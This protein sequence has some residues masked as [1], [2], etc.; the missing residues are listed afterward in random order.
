MSEESDKNLKILVG[1]GLG[2]LGLHYL[3]TKNSTLGEYVNVLRFEEEDEA[4]EAAME[5]ERS[6][7]SQ[8]R[9]VDPVVF[10]ENGWWVVA[11]DESTRYGE[12]GPS[13]EER[14]GDPYQF[15]PAEEDIED[16]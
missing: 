12:V 3:L 11:V 6:E 10:E 13:E 16:D 4:N 14:Y 5:M 9:H 1:I 15:W 8:G 2:V 7:S